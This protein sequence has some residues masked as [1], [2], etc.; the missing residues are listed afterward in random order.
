MTYVW[1]E[2]FQEGKLKVNILIVEI[3]IFISSVY[4]AIEILQSYNFH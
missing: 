2:K 3:R 1:D 4:D